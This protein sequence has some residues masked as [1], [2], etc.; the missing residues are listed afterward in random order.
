VLC[1]DVV[2]N[3]KVIYV[4]GVK[5]TEKSADGAISS[6]AGQYFCIFGIAITGT[7]YPAWR[8]DL[9]N[10][11]VNTT[12]TYAQWDALVAALYAAGSGV[13]TASV[14]VVAGALSVSLTNGIGAVNTEF[15]VG[16]PVDVIDPATGTKRGATTISLPPVANARKEQGKQNVEGQR[17]ASMLLGL[18]SNSHAAIVAHLQVLRM[19]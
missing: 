18:L 15:A 10:V 3:K 6:V 8:D 9:D 12:A 17:S 11:W 14:S 19:I 2:A 1:Y 13:D 5:G 4:D 7:V 16:W